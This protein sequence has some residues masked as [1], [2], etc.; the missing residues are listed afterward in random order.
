MRSRKS[1]LGL[2]ATV[3]L[4][5]FVSCHDQGPIVDLQPWHFNGG[6]IFELYGGAL[7]RGI[8][9]INPDEN[10]P[11][12][13]CLV[14]GG[15]EPRVSPDSKSLLQT[16]FTENGLELFVSNLDG[17]GGKK[18]TV[19]DSSISES[20]GDWSPDMINI[21]STALFY[22][23]Y[24]E[25]IRV[26]K[27]DGSNPHNI[28]D[29][30]NVAISCEPRWSPD[31]TKIA[32]LGQ[33]V[34]SGPFWL[35]II[36]SEGTQKYQYSD[37]GPTYPIWSRDS[38]MVVEAA[39][40]GQGLQV[41]DVSLGQRKSVGSGAVGGSSRITWLPDGRLAYASTIDSVVTVYTA[42]LAPAVAVTI[43]AQGFRSIEAVV[44]SPAG[45]RLAI[46]GRRTEP[47]LS[48]Y[49]LQTD[50][51]GLRRIAEIDGSPRAILGP[52]GYVNWVN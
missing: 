4:G 23:G 13:H 28:T 20:W 15:A 1:L 48:L 19:A 32:Y 29:T 10:S 43:V 27:S 39:P 8:Y 6:I 3:I 7:D 12:V 26:M 33:D 47:A 14:P 36:S 50:G 34:F 42:T 16:R 37:V 30:S 52:D 17:S 9:S 38:R 11:T 40:S 35:G 5:F 31:G 49:T 51:S 41:I 21:V 45:D 25:A 18:I 46:I 2:C 22:P 24:K 44:I